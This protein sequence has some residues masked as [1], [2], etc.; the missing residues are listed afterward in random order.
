MCA[1][2][3][4]MWVVR[5]R[6]GRL[7]CPPRHELH[8]ERHRRDGGP[9][10][11]LQRWQRRAVFEA[12]V[13]LM[14]HTREEHEHFHACEDVTQTHPATYSERHEVLRSSDLSVIVDE[15]ARVELLGLV[16]KVGVH[17]HA[18]D[19]RNYLRTSRDL[20]TV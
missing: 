9:D 20:V 15:S 18:V 11:S 4:Q 2:M 16:P 5:D 19:E 17:V 10:D 1:D 6:N 14:H 3:A 13:K 8:A 7:G 12:D